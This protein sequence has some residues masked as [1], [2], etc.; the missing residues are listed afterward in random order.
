MDVLSNVLSAV[1]LTGAVYIEVRARAP[2]IAE[3]PPTTEISE[4]VM[5]GF[6][7]I[8]AFH[9]MMEGEC[10]AQLA[11]G[12]EPPV[13]L[14]PG[15]AVLFAGGEAHC[16]G[17]EPGKQG[18]PDVG[19]YRRLSERPVP[20][21]LDA[22]RGE[23]ALARIVCGYLGCDARPFNPIVGALPRT[24]HVPCDGEYGS[25]ISELV[26]VAL[27]ESERPRAGGECF[28]AR[29]SELVFLHAVRQHVARLPPGAKGWLAGLRDRHI[30][31]A[32][33]LMHGRPAEPWTLELL[34]REVGLSR[35]IFAERF[36]HVVG[37]P[38]MHYLGHW[39]LQLAA[40]LLTND[41]VSIAQAAAAVGYESEAAFNRAFKRRVGVPP[42]AWRR[43]RAADDVR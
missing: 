18:R 1:R 26:R 40:R 9:L 4:Q 8:I 37:A 34:A 7:H 22:L 21:T 14:R 13:R 39:R 41:S 43:K 36:T 35:S 27:G 33:G 19:L 12:S 17:S 23:G 30:G 6:E 29:L 28:L 31:A 5:P 11:D 38:P 16:M 20:Y 25:L 2:W 24:L 42:G 10:F 3:T 32:L 15:D